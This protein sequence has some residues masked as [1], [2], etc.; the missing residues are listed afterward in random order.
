M[1][2]GN[3]KDKKSLSKAE[4]MKSIPFGRFGTT[5]EVARVVVFLLS[6]EANY[7]TGQVV[8]IDGGLVM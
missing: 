5:D 2:A 6:D 1:A 4:L 7:I 3:S 8:Q